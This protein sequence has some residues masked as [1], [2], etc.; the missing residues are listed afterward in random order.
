[1]P[2]VQIFR[3]RAVVVS[4]VVDLILGIV[5]VAVGILVVLGTHNA[6]IRAGG[7]AII[8]VGLFL[9]FTGTGRMTAKLEL[10]PDKVVW[11]WSFS[12]H[13]HPVAGLEDAS[14]V[15]PGSPAQ[16]AA[17][18]AWIAGGFASVG[19]WWLLSLLRSV[20]KADPTIGTR[21]LELIPHF[22]APIR[23]RAIG[24]YATGV[25]SSQA[26]AAEMAVKQAIRLASQ[27]P[28]V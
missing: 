15:E 26:Y 11:T 14:L 2:E 27:Q 18:N 24:T 1:M 23:I 21:Q 6:N 20:S 22:G 4:G 5:V 9:V 16:G 3:T 13:H 17:W 12:S 19:T 7:A 8:F 25:G 28:S 10:H